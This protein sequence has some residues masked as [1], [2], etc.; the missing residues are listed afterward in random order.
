MKTEEKQL[1]IQILDYLRAQYFKAWE[2]T[3]HPKNEGSKRW[4][5]RFM[6]NSKGV[7]DLIIDYPRKHYHGLR[8]EIKIK[9]GKMSLDQIDWICNY[10]FLGYYAVSVYSFEEAKAAIDFYML[11]K[12]GRC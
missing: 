6:G 11:E 3:F 4:N 1:Q 2:M 9:T 8:I 10:N 7:P 5:S 12:V